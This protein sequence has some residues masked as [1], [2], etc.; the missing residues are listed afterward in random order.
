MTS[1]YKKLFDKMF[2]SAKTKVEF[3][4]ERVDTVE[5]AIENA[6]KESSAGPVVWDAIR[7]HFKEEN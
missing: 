6:R 3:W 1:K 2:D 4:M 7:K 5:E